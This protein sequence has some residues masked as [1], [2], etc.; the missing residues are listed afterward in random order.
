[1]EEDASTSFSPSPL[2]LPLEER[3]SGRGQ[4]PERNRKPKTFV[5]KVNS[6]NGGGTGHA[7]RGPQGPVGGDGG[8]GGHGPNGN[9]D[10]DGPGACA[11]RGKAGGTGGIGGVG[12]IGQIGWAGPKPNCAWD[13]PGACKGKKMRTGNEKK[14]ISKDRDS[15]LQTQ[16]E[17]ASEITI[18]DPK[19]PTNISGDNRNINN[20]IKRA[21]SRSED[22]IYYDYL[23][24]QPSSEFEGEYIDG[25]YSENMEKSANIQQVIEQETGTKL[26][27]YL[28]QIDEDLQELRTLDYDMNELEILEHSEKIKKRTAKKATTPM[29]KKAS[30]PKIRRK[31]SPIGFD[32]WTV[33]QWINHG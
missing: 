25:N 2:Y 13:G 1:M 14:V 27:Q 15:E 4:G 3:R 6:G 26:E 18:G 7:K 17:L 33:Q 8:V 12:G 9:C 32:L 31:S 11:G 30:E 16:T 28:F 10:W 24:G 22:P 21:E 5:S 23:D 19:G 20:S 29:I